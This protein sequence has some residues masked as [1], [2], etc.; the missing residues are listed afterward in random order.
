MSRLA[1]LSRIPAFLPLLNHLQRKDIEEEMLLLISDI[2]FT[3]EN[4]VNKKLHKLLSQPNSLKD[5][6]NGINKKKFRRYQQ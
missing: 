2:N 1:F 6:E 4:F 5:G 3:P